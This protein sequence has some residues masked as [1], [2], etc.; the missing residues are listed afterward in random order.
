MTSKATDF[1]VLAQARWTV[2]HNSLLSQLQQL[3]QSFASLYFI[4]IKK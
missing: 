4:R 1:T 2:R 3:K